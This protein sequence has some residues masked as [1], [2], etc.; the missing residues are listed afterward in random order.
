MKRKREPV[1]PIQPIEKS[2]KITGYIYAETNKVTVGDHR[3]PIRPQP[4][5]P[6]DDKFNK[7]YEKEEYKSW[8]ECL[9]RKRWFILDVNRKIIRFQIVSAAKIYEARFKF[10]SLAAINFKGAW[11]VENGRVVCQL[12]EEEKMKMSEKREKLTTITIEVTEPP[13]L[14]ESRHILPHQTLMSKFPPSPYRPSRVLLPQNNRLDGKFVFHEVKPKNFSNFGGLTHVH[15]VWRFD[16]VN[17]STWNLNKK[18][19]TLPNFWGY[20][21]FNNIEQLQA[22]LKNVVNPRKLPKIKVKVKRL[23]RVTDYDSDINPNDEKVFCKC[24]KKCTSRCPCVK[25]NRA[26]GDECLKCGDDCESFLTKAKRAGADVGIFSHCAKDYLRKT[27]GKVDLPKIIKKAK[28]GAK[29]ELFE[30]QEITDEQA[31][32]LAFSRGGL[33]NIHDAEFSF[34]DNLEGL[35]TRTHRWHHCPV[36]R[37]C[38]Y[39]VWH[40][41]R[42]NQCVDTVSEMDEIGSNSKKCKNCHP[43]RY[44]DLRAISYDEQNWE[45]E[46]RS[47]DDEEEISYL[48]TQEW[49]TKTTLM[50]GERCTQW[51]T[52]FKEACKAQG[53]EPN[54]NN[55]GSMV[56][57]P[58]PQSCPWRSVKPY[59]LWKEEYPGADYKEYKDTIKKEYEVRVIVLEKKITE[60]T[61]NWVKSEDFRKWKQLVHEFYNKAIEEGILG[62]SNKAEDGICSGLKK[63]FVAA[64]EN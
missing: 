13:K 27:K 16:C 4:A 12:D 48:Y 50:W 59:F 52:D 29:E 17:I 53:L 26:C 1:V 35:K 3:V 20:E 10:K 51:Q 24:K 45:Q 54:T 19:W 31:I 30:G 28:E 40:C 14:Y 21:V 32:Q 18:P 37:K 58:P 57:Y 47:T 36:C 46:T 5:F 33:D 61:E 11:A 64:E 39:D 60:E 23:P 7:P 63:Y 22:L 49:D 55:I 15:N 38:E 9:L 43:H 2:V 62:K 6:A 41:Q 25:N 34:C 56:D 44:R 42:C 8:H